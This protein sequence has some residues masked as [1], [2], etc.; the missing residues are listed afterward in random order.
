MDTYIEAAREIPVAYTGDVIVAGA[1]PAGL[2]AAVSARRAGADKVLLV[3]KHGCIGGMMTAGGVMNL[4]QF[5]DTAG[6]L[7]ARGV[8]YEFAKFIRSMGGTMQEP[9]EADFEPEKYGHIR[10]E[11]E[12]CKYAAQKF[13]EQNGVGILLHTMIVGAVTE[14][15]KLNGIIVENKSGRQL[16]KSKVIIDATGDGDVIA[17]SGAA[18][19]KESGD[20]VQPM[21]LTFVLANA[22]VGQWPVTLTAEQRALHKKLYAEGKYPVKHDG[23]G[24]FAGFHK[25]EVYCNATR[26]PGD[27]TNAWDL[28]AA[29]LECRRQI[30]EIVRYFRKYMK[31]YE[32][33]YVKNSG[34]QIGLRESRRLR[35][36][37]TLTKQDITNYTEFEDSVMRNNYMFD[38]HSPGETT[39]HT[40]LDRGKYYTIPYRCLIPEKTDGLLAA[41]RCISVTREALSSSRVMVSCMA[42]GQ[43]AGTAAA[44]AVR[45]GTEPRDI[46][47]KELKRLLIDEGALV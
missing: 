38:M 9:G 10:Q 33:C 30:F 32:N 41:G 27:S 36:V 4:R 2:I 22:A 12:I 5:S 46:D 21:T 29:E 31:G 18:F 20:I 24:L 39:E 42:L 7:A 28:T 45:S 35:G 25:N 11:P 6:H 34:I 3:E 15:N 17:Y 43:A 14:H 16:L 44:L 37:Y 40:P 26:C 47:V 8:P 1:G 23:F 19:E 13:C